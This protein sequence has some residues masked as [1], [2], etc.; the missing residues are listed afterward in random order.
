MA[1]VTGSLINSASNASTRLDALEAETNNLELHTAS[2]NTRFTT[3]ASYTGSVNQTTASLNSYTQSTDV[4]LNNIESFTSSINTTIK[5]KL[6]ADGVVSGSSQILGNSTIHSGSIGNYQF[7]SIGIGTAASSVAGELRATGDIVA[8]YSSDERLKEN[9][10]PIVDALSKIEA[11]GG[12]T[13]DWKE[14]FE[15]IHSHKGHDLGVIA[16]EVQ[17]VFP[18]IVNE[19][20]TGYLAV[21][22]IKLVP[23]LIEAIKELSAKVKDLENK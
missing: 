16:Q 7:N 17:S 13:Y 10:N 21:D 18:E 12:K 22:Y 3:L 15:T 2:V 23:V 4:R 14:G 6:N 9:I 19:R 1:T 20:E 5:A 11:I 8:F